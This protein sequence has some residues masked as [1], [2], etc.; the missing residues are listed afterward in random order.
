MK[1]YDI[2]FN[3]YVFNYAI[4]IF[5]NFLILCFRFKWFGKPVV[6]TTKFRLYPN[7]IY[8]IFL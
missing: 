5:F 2:N 8:I 7:S 1:F 6:L 4:I 3:L